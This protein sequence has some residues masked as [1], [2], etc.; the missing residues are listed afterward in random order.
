MR[1]MDGL[2]FT[3]AEIIKARMRWLKEKK[4]HKSLK[5]RNRCPKCNG[6]MVSRK[7]KDGGWISSECLVCNYEIN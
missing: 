1:V 6:R 2:I 5:M 4:I 7:G 3:E